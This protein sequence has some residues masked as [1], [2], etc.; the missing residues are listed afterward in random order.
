MAQIKQISWKKDKINTHLEF[1]I[2]GI[3]HTIINTFR[4]VVLTHIPI[5]AFKNITISENTSVFNN[6]YMKLRINNLPVFGIYADNPIY[7]YEKKAEGVENTDELEVDLNVKDESINSSTLKQLTMY[8]D[9][10]NNTQEIVTVGT[11][12]AK[13]YYAEKQIDSPYSVNIPIIKL[14]P[15]QRFKMSAITKLGCEEISAI[16][17]AVSIFAYKMLS[18]DTYNVRIESRGQLDEKKIIQYAYDNIRKLLDNFLTLIPDRVDT[19]GRLQLNEGDHTLG[20]L[21]SEGLMKHKMVKFAGY[22]SPH[23]LDKKIIFHYELNEKAN[24]KDIIKEVIEKYYK[25]FDNINKSI[26]EKIN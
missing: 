25:I 13:F 11:D 20:N 14:Q 26:Q 8:V 10:H 6:N 22:N 17:S 24:I 19:N 9:Y 4:R 18:D 5:Y 7:V 16:Y 15:N 1:E 23:L 21:I 12:D 3:D 2:K